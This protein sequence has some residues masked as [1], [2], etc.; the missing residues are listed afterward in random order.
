MASK[1]SRIRS[2][3][4]FSLVST[5]I[6][7]VVILV[8][9]IATS[10]VRHYVA[11]GARKAASRMTA[12]RIGLMLC[13]SWQGTGGTETYDPVVHLGSDLAITYSTSS[14]DKPKDF[15]LLGNYTVT[16]DGADYYATLSWKD[17][18]IGLRVLNVV[19]AGAQRDKGQSTINGAGNSFKLT[20]FTLV[21]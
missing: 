12:A 16:V 11:L 2:R 1:T 6:V 4:G 21:L 8:A 3:R 18:N 5:I 7:I 20:I 14:L 10:D 9:L 13:E 15:T 19:V 17:D